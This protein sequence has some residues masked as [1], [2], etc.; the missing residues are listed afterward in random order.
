MARVGYGAR[1]SSFLLKYSL[2]HVK[3]YRPRPV[4]LS[5]DT[6]YTIREAT[7]EGNNHMIAAN[8]DALVARADAALCQGPWTV[9]SKQAP[10][11]SG[12]KHDYVSQAPY[13]WRSDTPD[14]LPYIRRDGERNPETLLF[15]DKTDRSHVFSASFI[16]ALAWFYTGREAYA[17]HAGH[18]IRTWFV[19]ESTR[20]NPN[21][22]HAQSI[23]GL[24]QGR[25]I[26]IIDFSMGYTSVL[27]AAALLATENAPGWSDAD[28]TGFHSWNVEFLDWLLYSEFG[29]EE[30]RQLN[31]HGTFAIMQK[32]AIALFVDNKAVARDE[33]EAMQRHISISIFADGSQPMELERTRSW[34]YSCFSLTAFIRTAEIARKINVDLWS[35]ED[36]KLHTAVNFLIKAA[37]GVSQWSSPEMDFL[38]YAAS[39]IIRSS[40]AAGNEM[41]KKVVSAL[42][43]PSEDFWPLRPAPEQLDVV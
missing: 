13:W 3:M 36:K 42:Q 11:P 12:D 38:P 19:A 37:T 8:L 40:A 15:T 1:K 6:L 28:V 4:V 9:T 32:A 23:P 26:G 10:S 16:L 24:N 41:A 25:A 27:D 21:L 18:I 35:F 17:R 34:H 5:L 2:I 29:I 14:G 43:L 22:K 7:R 20:M 39:D 33:M 30:S 31:N